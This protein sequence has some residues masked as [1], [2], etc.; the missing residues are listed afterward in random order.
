MFAGHGDNAMDHGFHVFHTHEP[1]VEAQQTS[2]SAAQRCACH[3]PARLRPAPELRLESLRRTAQR[4]QTGKGISQWSM[5]V[6]EPLLM[7][8]QMPDVVIRYEALTPADASAMTAEARM[9][10]LSGLKRFF[11]SKRAEGLVSGQV[12][13]PRIC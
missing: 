13:P 12:H 9:R 11:H 3:H 8:T 5:H 1:G 6:P 2:E 4:L 7:D 10:L